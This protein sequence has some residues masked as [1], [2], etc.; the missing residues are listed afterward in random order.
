[1]LS[2]KAEASRKQQGP[3]VVVLSPTRELAA[4]SHRA[5]KLLLP[6]SSVRGSLLC[7][8][9]VAGT[10]FSRVDILI[11][12]PLLLVQT[13]QSSKAC[14]A[15]LVLCSTPQFARDPTIFFSFPPW[16]D[17]VHVPA[18]CVSP[19]ESYSCCTQ[20]ASGARLR[21]SIR[22]CSHQLLRKHGAAEPGQLLRCRCFGH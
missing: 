6:H 15:P 12:T 9:T 5:L 1:M 17:D 3:T 2:L 13:I 16:L 7:K 10:D 22:F 14:P 4:Q 19:H 20:A 11:A 8:A 18:A 21:G